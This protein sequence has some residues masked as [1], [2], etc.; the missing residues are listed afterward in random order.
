ME[1]GKILGY[2]NFQ[3]LKNQIPN[4]ARQAETMGL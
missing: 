2:G 3:E 4:F 1:E